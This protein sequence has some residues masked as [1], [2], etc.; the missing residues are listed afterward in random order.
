MPFSKSCLLSRRLRNRL[1]DERGQT[2]LFVLCSFMTFFLL[3]A[4]VAN[5]GQIV[6]RRVMLQMVADAGAFT[7]ASAQATAMNT[8]SE[9]NN[10]IDIAWTVTQVLMLGF[11]IHYCGA[12]DAITGAYQAIEGILSILIEVTNYGG[13]AWALMEAEFVTRENIKSLFPDGSVKTPIQSFGGLLDSPGSASMGVSHIVNMK[14]AWPSLFSGFK[15]VNIKQESVTKYWICYSYP[16]NVEFKNKDFNLPWEKETDDEITRFYWW[17]TAK[18]VD[19]LVL[20]QSSWPF[21]FPKVPE[22]T[23]V[24]LAKPVGGDIEPG[25]KGAKYVAKMLPL[26]TINPTFVNLSGGLSGLMAEVLH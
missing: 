22:M 11:T 1:G 24:A 18:E 16:I 17:V 20:P 5:V 7:G 6:N 14:K 12:D 8:I 2:T 13:A 19:A 4:M 21:G 23:A 15:I 9:F 10:Y 3:F 26:S 25:G